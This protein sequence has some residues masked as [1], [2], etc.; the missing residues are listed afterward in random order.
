MKAIIEFDLPE[1][2]SEHHA[3]VHAMDFALTCW[4]IDVQ[5]RSWLKY[6]HKF[7]SADK[8]L[9]E[10]RDELARLMQSRGISFDLIV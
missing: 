4:D 2:K 8:A 6:G 9:E 5:L 7:A 10:T 1:D 3:A